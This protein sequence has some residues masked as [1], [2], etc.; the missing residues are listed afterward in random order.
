MRTHGDTGTK[1]VTAC[2]SPPPTYALIVSVPPSCAMST[3]LP[4]SAAIDEREVDV[5]PVRKEE[6]PFFRVER[7]EV[8]RGHVSVRGA[9]LDGLR[10]GRTRGRPALR[11]AR[12]TSCAAAA[13]NDDGH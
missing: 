4:S 11:R 7:S 13:A 12:G 8:R 2:T 3:E 9:D 1:R 6:A 5:E 10:R